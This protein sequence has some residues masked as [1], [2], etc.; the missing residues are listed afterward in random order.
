[1]SDVGVRG[2]VASLRREYFKKDEAQ[3]RVDS[4]PGVALRSNLLSR[5]FKAG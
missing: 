3:G 4:P 2:G 5:T 1:M